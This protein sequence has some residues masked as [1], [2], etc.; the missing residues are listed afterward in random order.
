MNIQVILN[1]A[2][3]SEASRWLKKRDSSRRSE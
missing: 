2:P 1:G 3:R